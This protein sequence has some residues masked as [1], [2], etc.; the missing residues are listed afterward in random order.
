MVQSPALPATKTRRISTGKFVLIGAVWVY[1]IILIIAPVGALIMGTFRQGL[2][3]VIAAL[4]SSDFLSSF[5]L[6]IQ[7]SV[8]VAVIQLVFGTLLAWVL[9]RHNFWGKSLLNGMIDLPFAVSPVVVGYMLLLLFGRNSFLGPILSSMGIKVAF[10]VPGMV[11]ATLFVTLPMVVREMI[12]VIRKLDRSQELAA[13]TLGASGWTTFW[14]VVFPA[15]RTA[16][17]YGTTLTLARGL[18][19]FGAILVIG[20]GIQG[21]TETTTLYIFR[22]LEERQYAAAYS[23][24]LVIGLCTVIL[25]TVADWLRHR[26]GAE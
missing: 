12:P 9:V 11:L 15:L 13:E 14:R 16:L 19:E 21:R 24:A 3:P 18:G 10:A 22:A 26:S 20:G 6:T 23:A 4:T 2:Q 5:K 1:I 25:V 7:I 17:I 8:A